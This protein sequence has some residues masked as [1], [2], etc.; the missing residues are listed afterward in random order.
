MKG[1]LRRARDLENQERSDCFSSPLKFEFQMSEMVSNV[2]L[3][4]DK[5]TKEFAKIG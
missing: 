2:N 5:L 4:P 3:I 1:E